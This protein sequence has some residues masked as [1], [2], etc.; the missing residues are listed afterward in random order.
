[1]MPLMNNEDAWRCLAGIAVTNLVV[2]VPN[3]P[4]LIIHFSAIRVILA[5]IKGLV[6]PL[7]PDVL[8]KLALSLRP[9]SDAAAATKSLAFH[10]ELSEA[11]ERIVQICGIARSER[12]SRFICL[13][14]KNLVAISGKQLLDDADSKPPRKVLRHVVN[15]VKVM[16]KDSK[17]KK[18]FESSDGNTIMSMCE[19][20]GIK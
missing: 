6:L 8:D 17:F 3:G 20:L 13:A 11:M 2:S 16:Q 9:M 15:V 10:L 18:E 19:T 14:L 5:I 7:A 4:P 12:Y 1:M